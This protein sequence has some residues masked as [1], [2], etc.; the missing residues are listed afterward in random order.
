MSTYRWGSHRGQG[1][2]EYALIFA[3]VAVAVI[4]LLAAT[5]QKVGEV[6]CD[7]V[8]RT[9]AKIPPNI[10]MCA[11]PRITIHGLAG[12]QTVSGSITVEAIIQDDK[13]DTTGDIT[14]VDFYIDEVRITHQ[15]TAPY[16][17]EGND[18]NCTPHSTSALS[19]GPHILR[20][21]AE[22]ADHNVGE[23]KVPFTAQH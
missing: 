22:D 13:L 21:V 23:T 19:S 4:V 16:C 6:L 5:G 10:A 15:L 12:G 17:L 9:G 1:L 7:V 14:Y 8:I 18:T 3:L 20:I 11:A 2:V